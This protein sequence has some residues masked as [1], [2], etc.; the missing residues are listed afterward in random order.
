MKQYDSFQNGDLVSSPKLYSEE[1]IN[2]YERT[3]E[4][5]CCNVIDNNL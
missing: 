1:D 3:S 5:A 2:Y 4:C